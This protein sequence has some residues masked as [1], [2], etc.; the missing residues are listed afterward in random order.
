MRLKP[1]FIAAIKK[2]EEEK[3]AKIVMETPPLKISKKEEKTPPLARVV[4]NKSI[5]FVVLPIAEKE[6]IINSE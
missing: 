1:E 4:D 3:A 5:P 6:N 2:E